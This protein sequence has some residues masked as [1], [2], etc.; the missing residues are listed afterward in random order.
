IVP[1]I[2]RILIELARR[3]EIGRHESADVPPAILHQPVTHLAVAGR[4][5]QEV[6]INLPDETGRVAPCQRPVLVALKE[7]LLARL[8]WPRGQGPGERLPLRGRRGAVQVGLIPTGD[9]YAAVFPGTNDDPG[10]ARQR[11]GA[12][13]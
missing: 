4:P 10:D 3:E 6:L 11:P 5:A 8:P 13:L 12:G 7:H 2:D 9:E 1:P